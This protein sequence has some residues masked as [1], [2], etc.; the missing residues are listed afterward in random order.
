MT[1]YD[2]GHIPK[3]FISAHAVLTDSVPPAEL[4]GRIVFVGT[5]AIGLKDLRNTPVQ[6]AV[7]GVEVHAQ[8]IEQMVEQKFLSRPDYA[9][10]AEFLYLA[11]IGLLFV[12][13][14][15][16][17]SAA[18]MA[19][20]ATAF[21]GVG[22]IVPW[23]AYSQYQLLFD[24]IYPPVTLA[25]IYITGS[26]LAFMRAER[27][28]REIRGASASSVARR[29]WQVAHPPPEAGRRVAEITVMFTDVRGFTTI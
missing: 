19:V 21:V 9:A 12:W 20:V 5:S 15:P 1:L 14:L 3:R 27:D 11:A 2:T 29:W 22:I 25:V 17:L 23:L 18:T 16:R 28:R 10:G 13:L 7:P 26:A 8:L 24:P 6:D 4:E